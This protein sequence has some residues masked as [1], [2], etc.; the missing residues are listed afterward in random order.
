M[1]SGIFAEKLSKIVKFASNYSR[2]CRKN[3]KIY[4]QEKR[5]FFAEN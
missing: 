1:L 2:R 3:R 4:F 5:M